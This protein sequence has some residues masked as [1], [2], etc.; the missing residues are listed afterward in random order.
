MDPGQLPPKKNTAGSKYSLASTQ[1]NGQLTVEN[2]FDYFP[3]SMFYDKQGNN[4]V[5]TMKTIQPLANEAGE[6]KCVVS[7]GSLDPPLIGYRGIPIT[8]DSWA[9]SSL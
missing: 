3:R 1:A 2:V 7:G 5:L 9:S 6:L 8:G 4:Q